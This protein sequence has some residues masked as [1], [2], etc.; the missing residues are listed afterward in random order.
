MTSWWDSLAL[1][2]L[3]GAVVGALA[4]ITAGVG[5][6]WWTA[7]MAAQRAHADRLFT[8]KRAGYA[9]LMRLAAGFRT[10]QYHWDLQDRASPGADPEAAHPVPRLDEGSFLEVA[11][12]V[13]L[14]ASQDVTE[15]LDELEA[16]L[17]AAHD[18]GRWT[19]ADA[20]E[21]ARQLLGL[22]QAMRDDLGV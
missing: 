22:E 15:R 20:Y 6:A 1:A 2:T 17:F 5:A 13:R 10:A 21:T 3:V 9:T 12:T 8:D 16:L 7:R 11:G 18:A 19:P 14:V 4:A